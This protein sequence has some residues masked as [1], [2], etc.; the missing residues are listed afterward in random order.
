[1]IEMDSAARD[2]ALL[3]SERQF[4][5]SAT[6]GAAPVPRPGAVTLKA[7]RFVTVEV[8]GDEK[9][10]VVVKTYHNAGPRF[11]QTLGR[12]SRARREYENLCAVTQIGVPCTEPLGWME[13]RKLGCVEASALETRLLPDSRPLK[14]ILAE[15]LPAHDISTRRTLI[16]AM[17]RLVGTLHRS[18]LLWGAAKPRNVL[19]IGDPSHAELAVCD[20]PGLIR[21]ERSL[22]GSRLALIDAFDAAFSRSRKADFSRSERVRWLRAYCGDDR[23]AVRGLWRK[24]EHRSAL[25]HFLATAFARVWHVYAVLPLRRHLRRQLAELGQ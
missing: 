4:A 14:G 21:T 6:G 13:S 20:V 22:F 16:V 19:V 2:P 12:A 3:P 11:L 15:L 25:R 7:E 17:A 5:T 9:Q 1:M 24:L 23:T 8:H 18:G 10:G